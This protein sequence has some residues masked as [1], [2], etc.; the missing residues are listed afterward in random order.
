MPNQLPSSCALICSVMLA[1]LLSAAC[2]TT[3]PLQPQAE[4]QAQ[5][6]A[7]ETA[8]AQ[9]MADRNFAAFGSFV[10]DDAV[11]INGGQPL[12]GKAAILA[13]WQRFFNSPVA[14]FSW[15]P[16]LAEVVTS[17]G[18]A[19]TEGPVSLP[20]GTISAKFY[21]T[22]RRTAAGQWQVVFDNGYKVCN[23]GQ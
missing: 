14:P 1:S 9:S 11:F 12:R 4:L 21:T 6:R 7:A 15:R 19:Y 20:D 13:F 2:S 3:V 5:V 22:W 18:L 10:A 16:E 23:C 8:F 17:G